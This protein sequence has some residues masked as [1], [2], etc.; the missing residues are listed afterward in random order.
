MAVTINDVAKA[1]QTSRST[2]SIVLRNQYRGRIRP[3]TVERVFK[4]IAK[5][6]Y[7]PNPSARRMRTKGDQ[8]LR[9]A[10][11]GC[12]FHVENPSAH[13][14]FVEVLAGAQ[15]EAQRQNYHLLIG[16]G[17]VSNEELQAQVQ[18][19]VGDKVDGWLI[20]ALQRPALVHFLKTS[21]I[22][23]IYAGSA[24][25]TSGLLSQVRGDDSQGGYLVARHL[26]A[27]GHRRIA[28]I[29]YQ[30][31][32]AWKVPMGEGIQRALWEGRTKSLAAPVEH[33]LGDPGLL[34][35]IVEKLLRM[36]SRPTALLIRGDTIAYQVVQHLEALGVRVPQDMSVTGYDGLE[37]GAVVQPSIT[38]II[39]PRR[40]IGQIAVRRLL[41]ILVDPE[42]PPATTV[43]PVELKVREST[44]PA[45]RNSSVCR[46]ENASSPSR[47]LAK[48]SP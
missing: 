1:S 14:Y 39:A 19:L 16:H 33:H 47:L 11:L 23:A 37:L 10:V 36:K 32:S 40:Q 38:T 43:L 29:D 42:T 46:K 24:M 3:E 9:T 15:E 17:N 6:N 48:D 41:E 30:P 34:R 8:K 44:G 26:I 5:L 13:P 4:A 31:D 18:T 21:K 7:R 28:W 12:L 45:P 20:G 27:L 25:D 2:V 35:E 22:P